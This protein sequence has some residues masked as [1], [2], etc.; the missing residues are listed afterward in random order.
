MIEPRPY[1]HPSAGSFSAREQE[2]ILG[3]IGVY[4]QQPSLILGVDENGGD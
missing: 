4:F 2:K 1:A 3:G